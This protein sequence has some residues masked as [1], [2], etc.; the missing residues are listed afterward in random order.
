MTKQHIATR[1]HGITQ[2][3]RLHA[4][5]QL[6]L[7]GQCERQLIMYS[8]GTHEL[9]YISM[10]FIVNNGSR[11]APNFCELPHRLLIITP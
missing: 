1:G 4:F 9:Y 3:E 5:K 8:L 6:Y 7:V 11:E 2:A 10:T